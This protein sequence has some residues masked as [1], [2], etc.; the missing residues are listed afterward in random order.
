VVY[1]RPGAAPGQG[2]HTVKI[3]CP[4]CSF[5]NVVDAKPGSGLLLDASCSRCKA[6]LPAAG[7]QVL[8]EL[9]SELEDEVGS[10]VEATQPREV[11]HSALR[12]GAKTDE[13]ARSISNPNAPAYKKVEVS[14]ERAVAP[15]A[16]ASPP[17]PAAAA[18]APAAA[19]DDVVWKPAA[20]ELASLAQQE[21]VSAT[22]RKRADLDDDMLKPPE[23]KPRPRAPEA[24]EIAPPPA[25]DGDFKGAVRTDP[26]AIAAPMPA[27]P[28]TSSMI[29]SS[30]VE[31]DFKPQR[32]T[33]LMV[34]MGLGLLAIVGLLVVIV[35]LLL[36]QP[37]AAGTAVAVV[38]GSP[39]AGASTHVRD[40]GPAVVVTP[41]AVDAAVAAPAVAPDAALAP[42]PDAAPG[43][44]RATTASAT[45]VAVS[46]RPPPPAVD[47]GED[48]DVV[49]RPRPPPPVNAVDRPGKKPLAD[50]DKPP[51]RDRSVRPPG[52]DPVLFPDPQD[53]PAGAPPGKQEILEV[54]RS[55]LSQIDACAKQQ[56]ALDPAL[57]S[58][59][60]TVRFWIRNTGRTAKVEVL[61]EPHKN[62]P[63]GACLKKAV[64]SWNFGSFDGASVGPVNFPFKL[65]TR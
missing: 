4:A 27:V 33:A 51:P 47:D 49:E 17:A 5:E 37:P 58:G 50:V 57:A 38:A 24:P 7:A 26:T 40:A 3:V 29:G 46:P 2:E 14:S 44:D 65:S 53:C 22:R 28:R 52:C 30:A 15:P 21:Y 16:P 6:I 41:R 61:T 62:A 13:P 36:R 39:D 9:R 25:F 59:T 63:V 42:G 48:D 8:D 18:P 19:S 1:L 20:S 56:H 12:I 43:R 60:V 11:A 32:N 10:I 64:E 45:A 34:L 55:H 35:V 54:V 31:L 23:I